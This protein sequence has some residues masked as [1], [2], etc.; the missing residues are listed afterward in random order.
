MSLT[1]KVG[2]F[3]NDTMTVRVCSGT[4]IYCVA[5]L[6]AVSAVNAIDSNALVQTVKRAW[7][8]KLQGGIS[9]HEEAAC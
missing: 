6:M 1:T 7:K 8:G 3:Y 2:L 5:A 9:L 4:P